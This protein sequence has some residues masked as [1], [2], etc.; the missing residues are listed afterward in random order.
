VETADPNYVVIAS[1]EKR[2]WLGKAIRMS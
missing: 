1:I 2:V